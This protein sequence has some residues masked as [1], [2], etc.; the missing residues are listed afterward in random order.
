VA[1]DLHRE[2]DGAVLQAHRLPVV[3][4]DRT[5]LRALLQNLVSNAARFRHPERP[6][7]I[8]V[9]AEPADP[10]WCIEVVD[11]GIGVPPDRRED[12][13]TLLTQVHDR[14]DVGPGGSGIGLATCRRIAS[15]HGG[16]IGIADGD[17]GG[18]CVWITLP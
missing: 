9:T 17:D 2:L 5:Q 7:R 15:A 4:A 8:R 3:R 10:G 11:N 6:L 16:E 18:T 12:A 13:F 1:D 14:A